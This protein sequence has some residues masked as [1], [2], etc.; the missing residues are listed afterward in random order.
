MAQSPNPG[1]GHKG[2]HAPTQTHSHSHTHDHRP[3][4]DFRNQSRSKL[5]T[6][7][8]MTLIFMGVEVV[9][10]FYTGSLALLADAGHMF[11]DAAGLGLA[12][13]AVW[14][15]SRPATLAKSYGYYRTEILVSMANALMLIGISI[16]VLYN[17]FARLMHPPEVLSGPMIWVSLLGLAINLAAVKI[18]HS[19]A[20]H[21]LNMRGAYLEVLNDMIG[22]A[23]VLVAAVIITFTH[24]F[25]VDA[26]VS[27]LIGLLIIPR[28]SMLLRECIDILMEG[29]PGRIDLRTLKAELQ[30]V[31]GVIGVHDLHVWTITSGM[32]TLSVHVQVDNTVSSTVVLEQIHNLLAEKFGIDHST[33]QT[34]LVDCKH[35]CDSGVSV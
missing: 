8:A 23:G 34:E 2:G 31:A 6:V 28:T 11:S 19:S 10:G 18:L 24:W 25:W 15:S 5:W 12:L 27:G 29:T 20:G 16:F 1:P 30:S 3:H 35:H 21:S 4:H 33:V 17:A 7:L 32:D 22:S 13:I 26:V 14:F 9:S